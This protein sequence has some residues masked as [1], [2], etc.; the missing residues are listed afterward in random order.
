M[1]HLLLCSFLTF[2]TRSIIP[3]PF[4]GSLQGPTFSLALHFHNDLLQHIVNQANLYAR[5]HPFGRV[6]YHWN[7][8]T[9][10][11]LRSFFRNFVAIVL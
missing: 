2:P 9:V 10:D 8:L 1:T 3:P 5:L 4:P 11:K 7:D 6:N